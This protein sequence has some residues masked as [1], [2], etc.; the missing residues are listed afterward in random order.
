MSRSRIA[1]RMKLGVNNIYRPASGGA[2][3]DM[4]PVRRAGL[5]VDINA[6]DVKYYT[7][8][9]ETE[10]MREGLGEV[11]NKTDRRTLRTRRA[12]RDALAAEIPACGG[13][14]RVT[15]AAIAERADVT[16]R[17]FYS[18][19]RDILDLVDKSEQELLLGLGEHVAAISGVTLDRL[20]EGM[21]RLEPCPGSCEL[22][23]FVKENGAFMGALLGPGGDP[24]FAR[25]IED[26]ARSSVR[27]RALH[28]IA[29]DALGPFFDYYI[30]YSVGAQLGV[31]RRWLEGGMAEPPELMARVMTALMFIRPGD[32][33]GK[34][35]DLD[36]AR[37]GRLFAQVATAEEEEE[38][39]QG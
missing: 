14:D 35:L 4:C 28:G 5:A 17:T 29:A 16:R 39:P 23:A 30:T 33:Y 19:Y 22:L 7:P 38:G 25:K 3:A 20:Y 36:I 37:C 10:P 18:H 24:A 6:Q 12:L 34:P 21:S 32:L 8:N 13:L 26:L 31:L 15:V 27:E 2:P 1:G 9:E 11:P